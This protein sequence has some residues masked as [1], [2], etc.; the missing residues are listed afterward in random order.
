MMRR[1]RQDKR[2]INNVI[3]AMLGWIIVVIIVANVFIWNYE[4]NAIDLEKS[5]EQVSIESVVRGD[6]ASYNPTGYNLLQG[7]RLVSGSMN[8][9]DSD[10]S[11]YMTQRS[12]ASA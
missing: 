10:D 8:N 3:T 2:G 1:L 5:Q 11:L 12:F 9:L 4:M 7:T 6:S